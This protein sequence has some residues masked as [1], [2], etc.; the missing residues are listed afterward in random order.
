[1]SS[2][3]SRGLSVHKLEFSDVFQVFDVEGWAGDLFVLGP[4]HQQHPKEAPS[5]GERRSWAKVG[6]FPYLAPFWLK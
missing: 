4:G 1:M 2:G 5:R 3:E 6:M